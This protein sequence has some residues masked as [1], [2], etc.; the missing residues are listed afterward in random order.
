[1]YK[2]IKLKVIFIL[3]LDTKHFHNNIF[4]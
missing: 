2:N 3:M 1:M 4:L